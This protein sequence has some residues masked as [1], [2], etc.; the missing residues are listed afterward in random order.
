MWIIITGTVKDSRNILNPI[1]YSYS[2]EG[3][4]VYKYCTVAHVQQSFSI[5]ENVIASLSWIPPNKNKNNRHKATSKTW[6]AVSYLVGQNQIVEI[7]YISK[8]WIEKIR[9]I[10]KPL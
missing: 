2:F 8:K 7:N 9:V 4:K 10:H 3:K 6:F 1:K 5:T